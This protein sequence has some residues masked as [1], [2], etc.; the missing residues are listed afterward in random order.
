MAKAGRGLWVPVPP[1]RREW[2]A[3]EPIAYIDAMMEKLEVEYCIGWLS[4]AAIHGAS[5]QA[6]QTFDVAVSRALRDRV[7][8][9]SLLRFRHRPGLGAI[10]SRR[11]SL[12]AGR[13][14]V[15]TIEACILMLT[16]DVEFSGG[17]DNV[18]TGIVELAEGDGFSPELLADAA[19]AFSI[20][21]ARRAGWLLDRFADG[22]DT[23][24]LFE[25]CSFRG[26]APSVL[27][28]AHPASGKIDRKWSLIV[29]GEVDPDL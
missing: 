15:A 21:S 26:G 2:G 28:P 9:R 10:P 5:H 29:N 24:P 14:N 6:A 8:G 11:V 1:D 19:S 4:A 22:V 13:A 20:A 17:M 3:P 12:P 7:V 16:S 23:R 18:A 27:N 25:R